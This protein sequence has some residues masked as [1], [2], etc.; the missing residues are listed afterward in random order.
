[1]RGKHAFRAAMRAMKEEKGSLPSDPVLR[2]TILLTKALAAVE[3]CPV[4]KSVRRQAVLY[5]Y[6]LAS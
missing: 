1:M 3:K 6:Q 5:A 2:R 4:K